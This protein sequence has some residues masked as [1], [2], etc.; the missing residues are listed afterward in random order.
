MINIKIMFQGYSG[1]PNKTNIYHTCTKFCEDYWK[2]G[3]IEPD[4]KYLKKKAAMLAKY[5][6]PVH[7]QEVYDPGV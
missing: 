6:L 3:H 2:N 1:C 5:P 4:P 7:W